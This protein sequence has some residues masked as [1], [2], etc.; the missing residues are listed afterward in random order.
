VRHLADFLFI[1]AQLSEDVSPPSAECGF[2]RHLLLCY[3]H[4][5]AEKRHVYFKPW[6]NR[7]HLAQ[8]YILQ[9]QPPRP[10]ML[11]VRPRSAQGTL[12]VR[13]LDRAC[14][15]TAPWHSKAGGFALSTL[16]ILTNKGMAV[17]SI[18]LGQIL[19]RIIIAFIWTPGYMNMTLDTNMHWNAE[20]EYCP[21]T[22]SW[23]W[24]FTCVNR[25]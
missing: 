24:A 13:D 4:H 19:F 23:P 1:S 9:V 20:K 11:L 15:L 2:L 16:N 21:L 22:V 12:T 25:A 14:A 8:H 6:R 17:N 3:Q 5:R 18:T 10:C 7:C